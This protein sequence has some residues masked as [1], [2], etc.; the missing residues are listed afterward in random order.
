MRRTLHRNHA[1]SLVE[2]SIVLVVL[3]LLVGGILAGQ[4]LIRASEL[5]SVTTDF[6]RYS[7][8]I[9]AFRDRYFAVPG[10]FYDATR[11]WGRENSNADCATH[12]GAAVS[13]NGAC[14]GNDNGHLDG[15]TAGGSTEY[16]QFWRQLTLAGLIEG[17]YDGLSGA[18]SALACARG[19]DCPAA[20]INGAVWDTYYYGT[21]WP[22]DGQS[23]AGNYGNGHLILGKNVSNGLSEQAIIKPEEA[24]NI[25]Q[26][27]DDGAP[28]TGKLIVRY[29]ASC[30]TAASNADYT[31][32]YNLASSTM[33]CAL[34]FRQLF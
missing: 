27:M 15:G 5:R 19:I 31:S 18:A 9:S 29:W 33:S 21:A 3:G 11:V 17:N 7:T 23:Y 28:G 8:A 20:K 6:N 26:K 10:D 12:S 4:S 16:H 24:W 13:A 14:D 30:A 2:L 32:P 25:D 1:F 22:G 34:Y